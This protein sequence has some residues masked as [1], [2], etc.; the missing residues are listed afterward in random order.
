MYVKS[1]ILPC[2]YKVIP[3]IVDGNYNTNINLEDKE[4]VHESMQSLKNDCIGDRLEKNYTDWLYFERF[5]IYSV[6]WDVNNLKPVLTTGAQKTSKKTIRLFSRYYLFK[7]YR[8][9]MKEGIF[10]KIDNFETDIF[11]KEILEHKYP[12][13]FWSRDKSKGFFEKISK[14]IMFEDWKVYPKSVEILYKNNF[15]HIMY[16][17]PGK[18]NANIYL[19]E[20]LFRE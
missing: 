19:N 6:L 11:H 8:T 16:T 12:F 9:T 5:V 7:N 13:I 14:H 17:G 4:I 18:N 1:K 2:G 15:Q 10:N 20:L 3:F